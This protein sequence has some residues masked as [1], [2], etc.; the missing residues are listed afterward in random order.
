MEFAPFVALE[1]GER[2]QPLDDLGGDL[3]FIAESFLE[4]LI[5][6]IVGGLGVRDVSVTKSVHKV[7]DL[8]GRIFGQ[9][10]KL[11]GWGGVCAWLII[12]VK[13]LFHG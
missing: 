13:A 4:L 6:F 11:L 10:C 3:R 5:G 12:V 1:S 8:A 7:A 9:E 2:C